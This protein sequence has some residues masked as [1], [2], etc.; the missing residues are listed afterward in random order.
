MF[1]PP[2]QAIRML[3][4]LRRHSS[5]SHETKKA[6][7]REIKKRVV[8][9]A[10][11]SVLAGAAAIVFCQSPSAAFAQSPAAAPPLRFVILGDRTGESVPAVYQAVWREIPATKP[12][13][14]VG[15][16]DSIEGLNDATAES[17]WIS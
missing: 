4:G 10:A 3:R 6:G 8:L 14:V 15:V 16:G 12:T 1:R 11:V 7:R 17:E 13:F 2:A 9:I 5:L